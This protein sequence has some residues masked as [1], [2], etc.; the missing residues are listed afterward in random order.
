MPDENITNLPI[1]DDIIKHG[2]ADKAG[3]TPKKRAQSPLQPEHPKDEA[4]VESQGHATDLQASSNRP[5][6]T[7]EP[8]LE[9][10]ITSYRPNLDTLTEEILGS[11]VSE[12]EPLLRQKIRH[13]LQRHFPDSGESD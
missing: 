7:A 4:A 10:V 3:Q 12:M 5:A 9:D 1:L 13:A 8:F 6:N 2:D 11:I